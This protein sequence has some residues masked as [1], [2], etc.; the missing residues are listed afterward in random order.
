MFQTL[1]EWKLL[2]SGRPI[3]SFTDILL[4][5]HCTGIRQLKVTEVV[6]KHISEEG[7]MEN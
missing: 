4:N 5:Y 7:K 3:S 1:N 6:N 2:P